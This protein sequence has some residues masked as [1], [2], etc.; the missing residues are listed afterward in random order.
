VLTSLRGRHYFN[1]ARRELPNQQ[2]Y[3]NFLFGDAKLIKKGRHN[4]F[5][6]GFFVGGRDQ[7]AGLPSPNILP[8]APQN[9][10]TANSP[11]LTSAFPIRLSNPLP[12]RQYSSPP[13]RHK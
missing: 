12:I 3:K 5:L 8:H 13:I 11:Q 10:M 2:F 1:Q 7:P 4:L 9:Y 6:G